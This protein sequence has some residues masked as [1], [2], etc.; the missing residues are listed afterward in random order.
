MTVYPGMRSS[1]KKCHGWRQG[2]WANVP[3][4][5]DLGEGPS[6]DGMT[7]KWEDFDGGHYE[8]WERKKRASLRKLFT[9]IYVVILAC[10]TALFGSALLLLRSPS[11]DT[12][13]SS[14]LVAR[15]VVSQDATTTTIPTTMTL[16]TTTAI[17]SLA[18]SSSTTSASPAATTPVQIFQV[19]SPVLGST[20]LIGSN[21]PV[22]NT[23]ATE[24][25]RISCQVTLMEHS[26]A[27]SFGKPFVG[28]LTQGTLDGRH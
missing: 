11:A 5:R 13:L 9:K 28:A 21:G 26:F 23:N 7:A 15:P 2:T 18:G 17:S 22:A 24:A 27:T 25:S 8:P 12:K 14:A 19:F 16:S 10:S 20:G 6:L 3:S 4:V 1:W